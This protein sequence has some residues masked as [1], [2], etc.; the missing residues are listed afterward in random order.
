MNLHLALAAL[1]LAATPALAQTEMVTIPPDQIGQIFCIASLGNDMAPV[2][3]LLTPHLTAA[4]AT[5]ET[6]NAAIAAAAP[7]D[8][9][10][11]GDGLPWRSFPDYADGCVVGTVTT[12]PAE[13]SVEIRYSF[14][15]YP[16]A[17]YTDTLLL[18]PVEI[19]AG[20]AP[21]WRIDDIIL[22]NDQTMTGTL[23]SAFDGYR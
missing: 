2:E 3:A 21:F 11:L 4:I 22:A 1:A 17:N 20:L 19:E 16:D 5:A 12:H 10:P 15:D 23:L 9:P 8:K 7:G 14:K 13:A 6:R 18:L